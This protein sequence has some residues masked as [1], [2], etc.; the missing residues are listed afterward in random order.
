MLHKIVEDIGKLTFKL[1]TALAN[2]A[3]VP[4]RGAVAEV[5]AGIDYALSGPKRRNVAEN[6]AAA[7]LPATRKRVFGIFKL[8]AT[9]VI[10]MF[11]SSAWEND[12]ILGWCELEGRDEL[13]RALAGG[14]GV[15]LVS[16]HT[17]SWEI[18]ARCLQALG[19]RLHVVAGVQ[20]NRLFTGAVREAKEKR[21]IEVINPDDSYR[22]LLKALSANGV[23]ILLV[24]GNIYTGG[25][26]L[27]FFG[28]TTRLPDGP[29]KL[30][31]TS[32]AP[33]LGGFC[34]RMGNKKHALHVEH[35]MSA[36]DFESL[37][38]RD[39]LARIYGTVE[40]FIGQN[41]DQWC[42]FRRLWGA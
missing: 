40:R 29:A 38:E 31:R 16:V 5:C 13:E 36:R 18:G 33:I 26:E 20:M 34:R 2:A 7:G 27:P 25:A 19:Y 35:I 30:S 41:A 23:V 14:K 17:G 24:D 10:E 4:M 1:I 15:I 22:K 28:R 42:M 8:H 6:I 3:P 39:A 12:I 32:G 37:P 21:G 9:N 11:A